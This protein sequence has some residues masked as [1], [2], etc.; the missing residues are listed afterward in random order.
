VTGTDLP[1]RDLGLL[2]PPGSRALVQHD[3]DRARISFPPEP[4]WLCFPVFAAGLCLIAFAVLAGVAAWHL[5]ARPL[6][7]LL[8]CPLLFAAALFLTWWWATG[9]THTELT[10]EGGRLLVAV[11]ATLRPW[12]W[13]SGLHEVTLLAIFPGLRIVSTDQALT[14]WVGDSEAELR[15][16]AAVLQRALGDNAGRP[17][18]EVGP[19][20]GELEVLFTARADQPPVR[21]FVRVARG[22]LALRPDFLTTPR[23]TFFAAPAWTPAVLWRA[24]RHRE[25][26]LAP[27]DLACRVDQDGTACVRIVGPATLYLWCDHKDALEEALARFWGAAG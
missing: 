27:P 10:V 23:F 14:L 19:R 20:P 18:A 17:P 26:P 7:L 25:H 13:E 22:E 24:W 12:R 5:G 1:P 8:P 9:R 2:P 15:W 4:A 21:G 3:G 6:A 16:V 11:T